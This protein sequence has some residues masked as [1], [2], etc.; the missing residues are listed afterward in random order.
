MVGSGPRSTRDDVDL[1]S[2]RRTVARRFDSVTRVVRN[3]LG[4][5]DKY[6]INQSLMTL[7]IKVQA[8]PSTSSSDVAGKEYIGHTGTSAPA[9]LKGAIRILAPDAA[10]LERARPPSGCAR[11]FLGAARPSVTDSRFPMLSTLERPGL[12]RPGFAAACCTLLLGLLLGGC[13]VLPKPL[14]DDEVAGRVRDDRARMYAD[15]EPL[16]A[17]LTIE[18]A[19]AR[20]IKYNLDYRLRLMEQAL[21][22]GVLD[23]TH[24]EMLPRLTASAGYVSRDSDL[25][26]QYQR[27]G[28]PY[29]PSLPYSRSTE[30]TRRIAGA[31]LSWN[32]LDFGVSYYRA[33][34]QSDQVLIAEERK[35]KVVQNLLQDIRSAYWRALGAQ[36]LTERIDQLLARANRG[37]EQSR[38]IERQ[39][40]QPVPQTLGYQRALL[41]TITLLQNR[42][43]ELELARAEL[44]ALMNLPPG[45]RFSLS[46]LAEP[47]L[48]PA[49][50]GV[51]D[52]EDVALSQRPE[53][54][55]EDYRKRISASEVRRALASTLPNISF[56]LG[57]Q[58]DSNKFL[59]NNDWVEGGIRVS[60]NLLRLASIP[61]IQRQGEAQAQVDDT[62][63]MSQAMAVLTQVRVATM[64]YGL[65]RAEYDTHQA[66]AAVDER[67]VAYARAS[68]RSRVESDLELIRAEARAVLS[69]YQRHIAYANAQAAWGRLYNSLG[70]D[71]EANDSRASVRALAVRIRHSLLRWEARTFATIAVDTVSSLPV[72]LVLD[73]VEGAG[74]DAVLDTFAE[75]LQARQVRLVPLGAEP[76]AYRLVIRRDIGGP[77]E[78]DAGARTVAW[79]IA[80]WRPNDSVVGRSSHS[81]RVP[82]EGAPATVRGALAETTRAAAGAH[83]EVVLDWLERE[84]R[85]AL[86]MR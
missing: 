3:F 21:Q 24:F 70:L 55:E 31:E 49:P 61:A 56:D 13:T 79:S 77:P 17:P 67:L 74:R 19:S 71:V 27:R 29:D 1:S 60:L 33:R 59:L 52:L 38:E 26:S 51:A 35:R 68:A 46:D 41:D 44:A 32:L 7:I 58:Y 64:R 10:A 84:R 76:G 30:N 48:P 83:A 65:A 25:Y 12:A 39:G 9:D 37:L 75:A 72:S 6:M 43:Q 50:A 15:Q 62:R 69:D 36:R 73:G 57:A 78:S 34:I 28:E 20:A 54:R 66:S 2:A 63:R 18:E 80:L 8:G 11:F 40:L 47:V 14:T 23:V 81:G 86:A 82:V 42:R 5:F 85:R 45:T 16:V 4:C 53:L 22:Q